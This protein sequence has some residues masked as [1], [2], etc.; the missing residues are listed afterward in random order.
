MVRV[1]IQHARLSIYVEFCVHFVCVRLCKSVCVCVFMR[2][3]LC[4]CLS[5]SFLF[6]KNCIFTS[7]DAHLLQNH[8]R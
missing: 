2:V 1:R 3:C 5:V 4:L 6:K 8:S 7:K